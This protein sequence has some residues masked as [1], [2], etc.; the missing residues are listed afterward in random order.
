[1]S[2]PEQAAGGQPRPLPARTGGDYDVVIVGSRVA[3]ASTAMLL[4][5]HGHR[6]MMVDR[7]RMPSDVVSTHAILRSGVLQLSR[8]GLLARVVAAG[9]PPVRDVTLGFG[10]ERIRFQV[11][12]EHGVDTLYA[13]RRTVLDR[14]LV[15][16]AVEAGAELATGTRM[17][18]LTRG[19]RGEVTG[20]VLERRG[21][22]MR[23]SAS[24]VIGADGV[25]S[26]T[27]EL[28]G[29]RAYERHEPSNAVTYAYYAGINE[30]G[31]WFQFTP[32]VNAGLIAT[33][34]GLS[35]VFVGRPSSLIPHF[36]ADPD[37][38]FLRLLKLAGSDL[39][40]QVGQAARVTGFRGT[41]GLPG[42]LRQPW[43]PGWAL[44][45][46][47][48]Y[49]K[50][51]ISAHGISDSLRDAELCARAIDRSLRNPE[52][53]VAAMSEYQRTRDQLSLGMFRE[54][55]AL[56][57]YGWDAAEASTRMRRISD[58]VRAECEVLQALGEWA[59]AFSA[60]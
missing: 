6:V 31:F 35:C 25:W 55:R 57:R 18:E 20:I 17:V 30:P 54:S 43:G 11:R 50:D 34:D 22:Q 15:D 47:A 56:A 24:V 45:G 44:V 19:D 13:P 10:E 28:V 5:G 51:P 38:E 58:L 21:A 27:A 29:A 1:M 52:E 9:T 23:V 16:A 8:W 36:R 2:T 14:I 42:F 46:D 4:A 12:P 48:G 33:N 37:F 59:P 41:D 3:G 60:A 7:A 40:D 39:A 32:G 53:R 49:T 26:R